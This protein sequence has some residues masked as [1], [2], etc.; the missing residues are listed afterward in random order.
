METL[1]YLH[2]CL[3]REATEDFLPD[4]IGWLN[5]P[6]WQMSPNASWLRLLSALVC[7]AILLW[8]NLISTVSAR[9]LRQGMV[10]PDVV[11]IQDLLNE[12]G[13]YIYYGATGGGKGKFGPQTEAQVRRFQAKNKLVVDGVVGPQTMTKLLGDEVVMQ[14]MLSRG[15]SGSDV[16][17]VQNLLNERGYVIAYETGRAGRGYFDLRTETAVLQYQDGKQNL[18]TI[19]VVN[20]ETLQTLRDDGIDANKPYVATQYSPL[21]IRSGPGL[22]YAR[23]GQLA[24]GTRVE[25]LLSQE[26]WHRIPQGWVSAEYISMP[27]DDDL[28]ERI[29]RIFPDLESIRRGNL[30]E[31]VSKICQNLQEQD[32]TLLQILRDKGPGATSYLLKRAVRLIPGSDLLLSVVGDEF[33]DDLTSNVTEQCLG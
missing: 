13:Y 21:N 3:A 8:A 2:C 6:I 18:Q 19:G 29:S 10:G 31:T 24:K 20:S 17:E 30:F 26:G 1:A 5:R 28:V 7:S 15:M 22:Q 12:Q 4:E 11:A 27:G 14:R 16:A 25:I 33:I 23:L 9:V 32:P